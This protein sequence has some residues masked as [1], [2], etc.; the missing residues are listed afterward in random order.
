MKYL[1]AT[2]LAL[3]F[4]ASTHP[5]HAAPATDEVARTVRAE[6]EKQKIPGAALLV[7][8]KGVTIRA[9]GY[10]MANVELSVPVKPDTIFQSGSVGKQFTATAV[11]MLV[12]EGKVGL[13][14]PVQ[15]YFTDAPDTWKNIKIRNLLSHTS[16][17]SEYEN[18]PRTKPDGPFYLRLNMTE[19]ELYKRIAA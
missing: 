15:K 7:A 6:M 16:G 18:G 12:E 14:D 10:G 9:E 1:V 2:A 17:L 11:M 13:D 19:D 3:S 4:L 8:R 5:A